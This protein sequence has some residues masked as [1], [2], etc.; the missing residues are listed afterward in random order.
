[1]HPTANV[2]AYRQGK[3]WVQQH[4]ARSLPPVPLEQSPFRKQGVYLITGGLGGIGLILAEYLARTFEARLVLLGRSGLPPRQQWSE[5]LQTHPADDPL[6]LKIA[7][8]QALEEH[9][10]QILVYQANVADA[11]LLHTIVQETHSIFGALHGVFHAAGI[12]EESAFQAVQ[13]LERSTCDVHFQSKVYGTYAL[14]Q[15]VA[16]IELDFCLLFSSLS[17]VLGGLGFAAY[18]ASNIFLD[19]FAQ[20]YNQNSTTPWLTVNWDTWQVKQ[21]AHGALGGTIAAFAMQPAEAIDAMLRVF[22]SGETHLVNSTGDLQARLEQWLRLDSLQQNE[23]STLQ[24]APPP[25]SGDYEHIITTIWQEVLGV[26]DVGI[27]E[28]FFDLGGNSLI[29][30]EVIS[31]LKKAFRRPIP[32]V[33]LFEAPTISA[34]THYLRPEPETVQISDH[35]ADRRTKARRSV[36]NQGVALIGMSGRFPGASTTE[37]FWQNLQAGV[38][39]VSFFTP[40]ELE[41]AGI[42]PTL[43]QAP[44]YV[45]A[46]PI[47]SPELVQGFDAAFFGYSPRE[48]ELTDP[49]HRIFLECAWEVLEQAGYDS[50]TYDG[51]IGIFGGTNIST[52][53]FSADPKDL[54]GT[55]TFQILAGND[56]DSLTSSVSYK[57]NLRGPSLTVQTFCSTSLVA[58]HMASQSLLNG[59]C[60]LALAGGSSI[61]V[62]SVQGHLYEPG[63]MESPDGHCRT[64]DAKAKGSMFG[65]GVGV[66]A[67]KRLSDALEDG[68]NILAVI[69]GSAVN[70][71]GSLKVSYAAPS[72]VGQAAVVQAALANADVSAE[73]I[74]YVE[75]HGTATELGDPIEMASLTK[76]YR[77]QTDRVNYCAIGSVKTNVGHLDR[78]AGVSGLIKTVLALRNE[79]I[80]ASLHYQS[81]NP[82]I[83]F[84]R[85]PFFVN[86]HLRPWLR[87]A[88]P[89]RAGINS[90]GMGG[91]N[92]H[93]IVEEAPLRE[94]SGPSR[95]WQLLVLS[96]RTETALEQIK[97]RLR[98]ALQQEPEGNLADIAYTLQV[99]RRRFERRSVLLCRSGEEAQNLLTGPL[100]ILTENRTDRPVAFLFA[101]VGEHYVGMTQE[102]YQQEPFFRET[103]DRCCTVLQRVMNVNALEVLFAE[104]NASAARNG[105]SQQKTAEPDLRALLGRNGHAQTN[106]NGHNGNHASPQQEQ[107][108]RTS[109]AQPILFIV[110]YALAQLLIQWGLNPQAM[111]GYS[112]GEY[113]AACL[114]GVLSLDDALTLV[115]HRAQLIQEQP[116][117]AMVAVSLPEEAVKPYL[118][119]HISLAAINGPAISVL[120][121]PVEAIKTLIAQ[122]ERDEIAHRR[123][124]TT[125]AFHSA[126]LEPLREQV[127]ALASTLTLHPP[128]IPYISNVTGTWITA[129]QATNPAYWAE[130]MCQTVR[131]ADGIGHLLQETDQVLIEIGPGQSLS[132]FARQHPDCNR[133]RMSLMVSTLPAIHEHQSEQAFLLSMLGKLWQCG[134]PVNWTGFY[135]QERRQRTALPTYPFERQRY[136]LEPRKESGLTFGLP[137]SSPSL[138]DVMGSLKREP[139]ADWFYIPG[140]KH[141]APLLPVLTVEPTQQ[142]TWLLFLDT[143]GL[144][145]RLAE[146]LQHRG[147]EVITVRSG[148]SF[149]RL[150]T[151]YAIQ[152]SLRPEA[153]SDYAALLKDLHASGKMPHKI[154][155]LWTVT[156]EQ[157]TSEN[158]LNRSFYSLFALAQALGD[159]DLERCQIIII[160][161]DMQNVTGHEEIS[162]LKATL[163]GPCRVVPQEYPNL[164]C[165]SIDV[166][167]PRSSGRQE[168]VLLRQLVGELTS[169]TSD[170]VVALRSNRRWVPGFEAMRLDSSNSP[171]QPLARLQQNGV[172]LITGGFGGIGLAFAEWLAREVQA[173]LVLVGRHGLPPREQW[174]ELLASEQSSPELERRIRKVEE[175]E[176]LGAQVLFLQADI[177]DEFQ[178]RAVIEQTQ[179]TFGPLHGVLH[180]AGLP[181]VG[182]TQL[183]K[184]EQ[185]AQVLAPKV[186]GTLVLER[187]LE[188]QPLDFLVLFSSITSTTGGGPGQIDYCAANAFLDA[189]A[190]SRIGGEWPTIALDWGEWQ[191]NAWEAGLAGYDSE[192]QTLLRENRQKFGIAFEEGTEA[193]LRALSAE[194]PHMVVSTQD[195]RI[196]AEQSKNFTASTI[197]QQ[198]SRTIHPRPDLVGSY[199]PPRNEA[200]QKIVAIWEELLGISPIGIN[201]NFFELGGNSL[202]GIDLIA[203]LRRSF[204]LE[205][206]AS[207]VLYEAPSVSD[208]AQYIE[209]G[210]S[211]EAVKGRFERGEKRRGSLKQRVRETKRTR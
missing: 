142:Q 84:E 129:E 4:E 141:S 122:L 17:A 14:A 171:T 161:N 57:L 126:Q 130:H 26:Q 100:P 183:K 11:D 70:N 101:G 205:T 77:T 90:L 41:A 209:K 85:S 107:L 5:W 96:A 192:V 89:R 124:E 144:G 68:D 2:V 178:M 188:G 75:A 136:W 166:I 60:D 113:V 10:A 93:V 32:A 16:G 154:V 104:G 42:D 206:L 8:L 37:Q 23:Q 34:L 139:L 13:Q 120:A 163:M 191:W 64:F 123:V 128:K 19:A 109:L 80:P 173:R 15:A 49:Q 83:D 63:G 118:N 179:V 38:E 177:S 82:E 116:A 172:Y 165:R 46:R 73:S 50:Q 201:D 202:N 40:E 35:L 207:H 196:I 169:E 103:L 151:P 203:R 102:L 138:K 140:W 135:T 25:V 155:H 187:V 185:A 45:P 181:G 95:P 58:V 71:D 197:L 31:K 160:S 137:S 159:T 3:R 79:Q 44:N 189:Y 125:H 69:K 1:M 162:P 204:N 176:A 94:P 47:L 29:A 167:L 92:A 152:Y 87:A 65:D 39:S 78:A 193:L 22:A 114:A 55:N 117:G 91:T 27:Y 133:E 9:G 145:Q 20:R 175:L 168:D 18:T 211:N 199:V 108:S 111:L 156:Q 62:P 36:G 6:S 24:A 86:T 148:E 59:E 134:V 180:T 186:Q 121:G 53:L 112:L 110:E 149:A 150:N 164:S 194:M 88:T 119:E 106:K 56:K 158:L 184:A 182:L 66:V 21:N 52:Y 174:S 147:D 157:L 195:F 131:F 67:L 200:E 7:R 190:H 98:D 208:M 48:A 99:G 12:T 30:L 127:T 146:Q 72:V 132:S 97:Q 33:A 153:Q 115:A 143:C 61:Q 54:E 76:A 81:P 28:N 51:L 170:A 43:I 198:Q 210:K 105:Q 74:S